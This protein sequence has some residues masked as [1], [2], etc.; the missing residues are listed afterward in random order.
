[1]PYQTIHGAKLYYETFGH[2]KPGQTPL[3]LIH[4][5]TQTGASCWNKV[6]PALAEDYYVIVPD[7]RGHGRSENPG[8]TYSFGQ[9]AADLAALVRALGFEKA[10]IIGHSN[11]GNIAIVMM[12]EYAGIVQTCIP[13]AGNAWLTE[14]LIEREKLVFTPQYFAEHHP[15]ALRQAIAL[16][17][18]FQGQGYA[19]KLIDLTRA[20]IIREPNYTPQQ[21]AKVDL[22]VLFIQGENDSVNAASRFAQQMARAVPFAEVWIPTGIAHNVH[23]DILQE[24][25]GQVRDFL[26][27]RAN[28]ES[29]KLY[30]FRI[31]NY[32]DERAGDFDVRVAVDGQPFGVVLT[33]ERRTQALAVLARPA[34]GDKIKV[35]ISASSP[36]AILNRP[37]ED[38][39]RQPSIHSECINQAR[40]NE[41]ARVIESGPDWTKIRLEHDGY[42]GWVH[43]EALFYCD[44]AAAADYSAAC[45]AIVSAAFAEARDENGLLVQK[46][47]FATRVR[48]ADGRVTLADGRQWRVRPQDFTA[49][50][51]LPRPNPA[52]IAL[53]LDLLRR[54]VGVPYLWGGR[55]PYGFDCSGLA[56]T[57]YAWMGVS[58]PRDAD[59]QFI[60]GEKIEPP[61]PGD[62]L[63]FGEA[64]LDGVIRISHVAISLGGDQFIHANGSDW[65]TSYN[66]FD[67][68]SPLYREWLDKYYRGARRFR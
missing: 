68:K 45:N 46:L 25:L 53:T 15:E 41:V 9:I 49:L 32:P 21:M 37:I 56:G 61:Q 35:L 67:P 57:F 39:R 8:Q 52:G 7:C 26:S 34:A 12:I 36:W 23:D 14:Q 59:Q 63:F 3:L 28:P 51:D 20:E 65:G 17:E 1:M 18:P 42:L 48:L 10:H 54:F 19:S 22:P 2:K 30:R 29:E 66:S 50:T 33:E 27:R 60:Q 40:M 38:L 58:I 43:N 13:Q 62:L 64:D 44:Q 31:E 5:S 47:V 6:A 11:G 16:H 55:S 4:G 24:W